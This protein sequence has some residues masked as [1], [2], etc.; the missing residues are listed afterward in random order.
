MSQ[1]KY[2]IR[3]YFELCPGNQCEDLLTESE[4]QEVRNGAIILTGLIQRADKEN[5]NGRT[6]PRSVLER[7]INNYQN[8][9]NDRRALGELTHSDDP[10]I[11]LTKVSHVMTK[12]WWEDNDLYGKLRVLTTP[13]GQTLRSLINDNIKLGI[14][15]RGLGSVRSEKGK[16]IVEEDFALV[17]F[18]IVHEPSTA[19]AFM[20]REAKSRRTSNTRQDRLNSL[21]YDILGR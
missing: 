14:S 13:N 3:E 10:E 6:Y 21:F 7:E 16:T 17:C 4:K 1:K 12:V 20:L 9:I 5:G 15:S 8:L 11:D 19:N 18:D 2:L